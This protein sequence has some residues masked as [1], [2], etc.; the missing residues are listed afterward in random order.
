MWRHAKE[1]KITILP[2]VTNNL[3]VFVLYQFVS[4][5]VTH[6]IR[7]A[8]PTTSAPA[9]SCPV[10]LVSQLTLSSEPSCLCTGE[11]K[12]RPSRTG[13][14]CKDPLP[15]SQPLPCQSSQRFGFANQ[16]PR[17]IVC[18]QEGK[19]SFL[20]WRMVGLVVWHFGL[21]SSNWWQWRYTKNNETFERLLITQ[22]IYTIIF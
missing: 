5:G 6:S 13:W 22:N 20:S 11:A 12:R 8:P 2:C 17:K 19:I 18:G 9:S 21:R 3:F 7:S 15:A 16:W 4:V 14:A 1:E 10:R